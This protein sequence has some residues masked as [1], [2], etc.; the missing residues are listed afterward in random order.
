[1]IVA[2]ARLAPYWVEA[3]MNRMAAMVLVRPP[4]PALVEVELAAMAVAASWPPMEVAQGFRWAEEA[5]GMA[6]MGLDELMRK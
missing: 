5:E 6:A 2:V 4:A 3:A 1:M